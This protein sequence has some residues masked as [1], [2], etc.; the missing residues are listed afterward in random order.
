[1]RSFSALCTRFEFTAGAGLGLRIGNET[2]YFRGSLG[3]ALRKSCSP[4]CTSARSCPCRSACPY[5]RWFDPRWLDGPSGYRD[6]PRPFL[7]RW[8]G[9]TQSNRC[10]IDL[11]LFRTELSS[12]IEGALLEAIACRGGEQIE[13]RPATKLSFPISLSDSGNLVIHRLRLVF[14]TPTELKAGDQVLLKPEFLPLIKSASERI[15]ILGRLYQGW[16]A[17]SPFHDL[18]KEAREVQLLNWSWQ[19]SEGLRRSARS[20][21]QHSIGGFTGWAEYAGP[22]TRFVPLLEIARWT[23]LGRQTV[24]GKGEIHVK[25]GTSDSKLAGR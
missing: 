20:G 9:L 6:A 5:G 21:A 16:A 15:W 25:V 22:L 8:A 10:S 18:W 19:R 4:E 2:N 17:E 1:M 13:A 23:G 7:L 11:V 3:A 24:W 12:E 14:A